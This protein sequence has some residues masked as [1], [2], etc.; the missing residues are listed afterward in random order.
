MLCAAS[1]VAASSGSG[2]SACNFAAPVMSG[3]FAPTRVE[4]K[5]WGVWRNIRGTGITVDEARTLVG[6]I[7]TRTSEADLGKFNW[8]LTDRDQGNFEFTMMEFLWFKGDVN[9]RRRERVQLD[10]QQALT[11][12]PVEIHGDIVRATLEIHRIK[13]L[14]QGSGGLPVHCASNCRSTARDV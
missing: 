13:T 5:G 2:G 12:S 3:V 4:L 7:K 10:I 8:D 1:T 11:R 9:S 6:E 14:A